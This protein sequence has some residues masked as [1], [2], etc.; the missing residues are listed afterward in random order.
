MDKN[1]VIVHLHIIDN[2]YY[3]KI[4]NVN[5][6]NNY[7]YEFIKLYNIDNFSEK[8]NYHIFENIEYY[9]NFINNNHIKI[10]YNCGNILDR[11]THDL[12]FKKFKNI[13]LNNLNSNIWK[14]NSKI[15]SDN[16]HNFIVN[17]YNDIYIPT[18]KKKLDIYLEDEDNELYNISNI[19]WKTIDTSKYIIDFF[20]DNSIYYNLINC[21][22]NENNNYILT[23]NHLLSIIIKYISNNYCKP[24]NIKFKGLPYEG[25]LSSTN[26][27]KIES[28]NDVKIE[29]DLIVNSIYNLFGVEL[30]KIYK[31]STYDL[32]KLFSHNSIN[33]TNNNLTDIT[34]SK[35]FK[36]IYDKNELHNYIP[37]CEYTIF[38]NIY[39]FISTES[40][41]E[42]NAINSNDIE[43]AYQK[44]LLDKL[45][46]K[47]KINNDAIKPTNIKYIYKNIIENNQIIF[48][49]SIISLLPEYKFI[50][51]YLYESNLVNDF[52]NIINNNPVI[53]N[54]IEELKNLFDLLNNELII[55]NSDSD[56]NNINNLNPLT[57]SYLNNFDK[58]IQYNFTKRYVNEHKNDDVYTIA[59]IVI[60]NIYLYLHKYLS[61]D[62]INKNQI[63]SDL[64]ELGVKKQRK[65]KGYFYNIDINNEESK[66]IKNNNNKEESDLIKNRGNNNV[67]DLNKTN[68]IETRYYNNK[69]FNDLET[70]DNFLN[71]N[72]KKSNNL[73]TIN[74]SLIKNS[75]VKNILI[76]DKTIEEKQKEIKNIKVMSFEDKKL[77]EEFNNI[78]KNN[79]IANTV[80]SSCEVIKSPIDFILSKNDM[81]NIDFSKVEKKNQDLRITPLIVLNQEFPINNP[82]S[83]IKPK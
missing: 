16:I 19:D 12:N 21:E 32:E 64:V 29:S 5:N 71:K 73:E 9:K 4:I 65:S 48:S 38:K 34:L 10:F 7:L 77:I 24:Y 6:I 50:S 80:N 35:D 40:S 39:S 78:I 44:T 2:L 45:N 31:L 37:D 60:D 70:I 69:K 25:V 81:I 76:S 68:L 11:L 18:I 8:N 42:N 30:N 46:K 58:N 52:I 28:D 26:D 75:N 53:S 14:I 43:F 61:P 63:G 55:N 27:I 72:N 20:D 41:K 83:Y 51:E 47:E 33:I 15:K 56:N 1:H 62:N 79:I 3:I 59:N 54:I 67:Y 66:S 17:W 49:D 13:E 74:N 82:A 23:R 57:D 36:I 22:K